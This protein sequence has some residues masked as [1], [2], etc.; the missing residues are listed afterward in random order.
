[1]ILAALAAA[2]V[3]PVGSAWGGEVTDGALIYYGAQQGRGVIKRLDLDSGLQTTLYTTPNRRSS[4]FKLKAG[5][6]RVVFETE[7]RGVR[8]LA[9]DARGGAVEQ[10][11]RGRDDGAGVCGSSARLLDVSSSGEALYESATVSCRTRRGRYRLRAQSADG[12]VRTI[13]ARPADSVYL[14]DLE[15]DSRRLAGDQLVTWGHRLVRVRDLATGRVRRF[16][17]RARF[18]VFAEPAVAPDGRILLDE[19][20]EVKGR[21]F[22][23]QTIRLVRPGGASEV[24]HQGRKVFGQPRFCGD[25][26]VLHT[27][28]QRGRLRLSLLDPPIPLFTGSMDP[29]VAASCDA[30]HYVFLTI[31][32]ATSERAIVYQLPQ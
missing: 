22:P 5:G 23:L 14:G 17:P 27:F 12:R 2:M 18:G 16:A 3:F 11:A 24:V 21:R 32:G 29:D 13:L 15:Q 10:V 9:M 25:R 7:S 31:G 30:E 26:A 28:D 4:V 8:I 19:F 1:M 20:R 6:G